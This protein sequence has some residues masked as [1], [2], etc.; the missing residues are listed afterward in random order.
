MRKYPFLLIVFAAAALSIPAFPM[1]GH[2]PVPVQPTYEAPATDVRVINVTAK[3]F[4]YIPA[5]IDVKKG[6]PVRIVLTSEDVTHGFAIDAFKINVSVEKGKQTI[7]DFT[8][9]KAGTYE[10]YCTVF[11]GFGH[12]GMRGRMNV[13]E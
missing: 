5:T 11:C 8:P 4:E 10:Y 7:I 3:Q 2:A 12:M 9:D 6:V 1:G 13:L